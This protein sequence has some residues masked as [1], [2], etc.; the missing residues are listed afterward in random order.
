MF[1]SIILCTFNRARLLERSLRSL[2]R[3]TIAADQY[4]VIVVDDGSSD[5]TPAVCERAGRSLPSLR[6]LPLGRNEGLAA[7]G[8]RGIAAARGEALLFIDDDCIAQ[9]N[10]A[11]RLALSLERHPLVSGAIKSPLSSSIKLS[12]NISQ[13]H[14]FMGR[15]AGVSLKS[16]AGAN[17]GIR[18]AL[19]SDLGGFDERSEVPDMEFLFRAWTKGY[20]VRFV[21]EAVILHDPARADLKT[22]L[23]HSAGR[24]SRMILLRNKYGSLLQTPFVLRSPDLI[25]LAAPII[26]LK[27]TAGVYAHNRDLVR[28]SWTAPLVFAQKLAWCWGAAHGLRR[29]RETKAVRL[30]RAPILARSGK[31][32]LRP[33]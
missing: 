21:P 12:H 3:Q 28:Y 26:A 27:V 13:F 22:I 5:E 31:S 18:R 19:L 17:M 23:R 6:Y 2:G 9:E 16:I 29:D 32:Q 4:E 33:E 30:G 11:E 24:A 10:W 25:L 20:R 8:N 14:P 1:A 15:R 7:A